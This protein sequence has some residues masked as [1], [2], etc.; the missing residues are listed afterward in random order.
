M[1]PMIESIR[2]FILQCPYLSDGRVNVDFSGVNPTEYSVDGTP[3]KR[4]V[5]QYVDG[6]SIRQYAFVFGSVESYGQDARNNIANSG[7][8][9]DFCDWLEQ[10][11]AAGNLPD[12]GEG[13]Q[14]LSIEAQSTGYLFESGA[15]TAYYQVQCRLVYFQE[16][17]RV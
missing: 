5:T 9:D 2:D 17:D 10:Q 7:F 3:V 1:K 15:D 16:G 14:A 4:I 11:T 8:Y 12:L 6:S 13:K